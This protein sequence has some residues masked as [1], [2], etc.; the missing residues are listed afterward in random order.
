[1]KMMNMAIDIYIYIH[2][3]KCWQRINGEGIEYGLRH[4]EKPGKTLHDVT[5]ENSVR[6][7]PG[8]LQVLEVGLGMF[9]V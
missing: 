2:M 6:G 8:K 4:R 5:G 1:M 9:R 3:G 7:K